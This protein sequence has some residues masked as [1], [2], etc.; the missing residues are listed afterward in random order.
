M[1]RQIKDLEVEFVSLVDKGANKKKFLIKKSKDGNSFELNVE[2]MKQMDQEKQIVTGIVYEPKSLDSHGEYMEAED[3][4][5]AAY[6]FLAKYRKIDVQ[7]SFVQTNEEVV[8]SWIAKSDEN[9]NGEKIKKGT[10]LMSV[11]VNDKNTWEKIK[12]GDITGFSLAGTGT[13]IEKQD[14]TKEEDKDMVEKIK[15]ELNDERLMEQIEEIKS[16]IAKLSDK[17]DED[18]KKSLQAKMDSIEKMMKE[19][20]EKE[21]DKKVDKEEVED[22]KKAIQKM[23]DTLKQLVATGNPGA[24]KKIDYN[25]MLRKSIVKKAD[26][27]ELGS[28]IR[29]TIMKA[30]T[31]AADVAS[32]IPKPIDDDIVKVLGEMSPLF[33]LASKVQF[34]GKD[35]T[36]P[37]KV[38]QANSVHSA[39]LGQGVTGS[40]VAFT[41]LTISKGVLQ[42]EFMILDELVR[43]TKIDLMAE[44]NETINEDFAEEIAERMLRGVLSTDDYK[45]NKFEGI[46]TNTDFMAK[47]V[48]E[49]AAVGTYDWTEI[50][51]M[52]FRLQAGKRVG[53]AYFVSPAA[54]EAMQKM[55][56][57][58]GQPIWRG[59]LTLG[60][61]P[62]FNGYPIYEVWNMGTK[63]GELDILFANMARFY[64]V[65]YD[66]EMNME[67][68]RKPSER[69][70]NIVTN[71]RLGGRI[72][73]LNAGYGIKQKATV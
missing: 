60:A 63:A 50:V 30:D 69:G 18:L 64:K 22:L 14:K 59:P 15:K 23:D 16:A 47:R 73:D 31:G 26:N 7:H 34:Q 37:V 27:I 32:V 38:K 5:K 45:G 66:F 44:V 58:T 39:D 12:S 36:L 72:R 43:D 67:L 24:P 65:G 2:F 35:I 25:A 17:E 68:D 6:N 10:W 3:I 33:G 9:I 41:H 40:K 19:N 28:D 53:A 56:D 8:E 52:P 42:S 20:G 51:A 13:V 55:K 48:T 29:E 1:P 62:T 61:P 70:T 11:K 46:E 54:H 57:T 71:S 4:E 49:Q 21:D